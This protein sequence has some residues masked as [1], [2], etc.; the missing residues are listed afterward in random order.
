MTM[1]WNMTRNDAIIRE[2]CSTGF[3]PPPPIYFE[4]EGTYQNLP[5]AYKTDALLYALLFGRAMHSLISMIDFS[6]KEPDNTR[7]TDFFSD[8]H[9]PMPPTIHKIVNSWQSDYE[10]CREFL[11]GVNPF[12]IKLVEN[13]SE[14]PKVDSILS[15]CTTSINDHKYSCSYSFFISMHDSK[16]LRRCTDWKLTL[17][18]LKNW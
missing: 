17:S 4:S 16:Y 9:F 7:W 6:Q 18:R 12:L 10:F 8:V 11:Q 1:Y 2:N 13:I 15:I 14:V 3:I 5:S